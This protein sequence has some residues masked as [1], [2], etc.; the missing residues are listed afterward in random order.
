MINL[1]RG[2]ERLALV[3][4]RGKIQSGH[5]GGKKE[6]FPIVYE[7]GVILGSERNE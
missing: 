5:S 4:E 3:R 6:K 1:G 7:R 2:R